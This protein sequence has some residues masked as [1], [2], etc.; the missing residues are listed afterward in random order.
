MD[1][2]TL[3]EIADEL[4]KKYGWEKPWTLGESMTA[5]EILEEE[6]EVEL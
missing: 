1:T 6:H 4:Q 3:K 2:Q 5:H